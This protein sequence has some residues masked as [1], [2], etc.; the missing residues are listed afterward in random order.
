MGKKR[1]AP[2]A[3][4]D[5]PRGAVD[6]H[7]VL[8]ILGCLASCAVRYE[9][10]L[11]RS[12]NGPSLQPTMSE[13]PSPA[14]T[15]PTS[16]NGAT[17]S[18]APGIS[19][20]L[21][22]PT[23]PQE[24]TRVQVQAQVL[25]AAAGPPPVALARS[26]TAAVVLPAAAVP[27]PLAPATAS[28]VQRKHL[29]GWSPTKLASLSFFLQA[30]QPTQ[31]AQPAAPSPATAP[32]PSLSIFG[33]AGAAGAVGVGP[34][35][36]AAGAGVAGTAAGAAE[37]QRQAQGSGLEGP[38]P[39]LGLRHLLL[40]GPSGARHP[41]HREPPKTPANPAPPPPLNSHAP[42]PLGWLATAPSP[43]SA[44]EGDGLMTSMD[45]PGPQLPGSQPPLGAG[46]QG[47]GGHS[48]AVTPLGK[49]TPY[50]PPPPPQQQ[51]RTGGV[52]DM[53]VVQA[54]QF[55]ST[56]GGGP[57]LAGTPL[58]TPRLWPGPGFRVM[59][60]GAEGQGGQGGQGMGQKRG[61]DS[62]GTA[63]AT[64]PLMTSGIKDLA[65][66]KRQRQRY[67]QQ[68]SSRALASLGPTTP[69]S[70]SRPLLTL[71]PA[72]GGSSSSSHTPGAGQLLAGG[73]KAGRA[74]GRAEH[75]AEGGGPGAGG[76]DTPLAQQAAVLQGV[77]Q[78]DQ[79]IT[80]TARYIMQTLD[81]MAKQVNDDAGNTPFPH[82]RQG[83]AT[84]TTHPTAPHGRLG[85]TP[86]QRSS[87]SQPP[88]LDRL[89]PQ[90]PPE[91][92]R[93]HR[94]SAFTPPPAMA[95]PLHPPG[96]QGGRGTPLGLLLGWAAGV[97]THCPPWF[98]T[99][100]LSLGRHRHHVLI[101][102]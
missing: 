52:K 53:Q 44:M 66:Y 90:E 45:P 41:Q 60:S 75:E 85:A 30:Q 10:P 5:E 69:H 32:A 37:G 91:G 4:L 95:A 16:K 59:G 67:T 31:P 98:V 63:T 84:S 21:A 47:G 99:L 25:P 19:R 61:R 57:S 8:E 46:V 2:G 38:R 27:P 93:A 76:G 43:W 35:T 94:N 82:A 68:P 24:L 64:T 11:K 74:A 3:K 102:A 29:E 18:P 42:L 13:T 72:A 73:G 86:Y 9:L 58:G 55:A 101:M 15:L 56:P 62:P 12:G 97:E 48:A 96:P 81:S 79:G 65:E 77:P 89:H 34:A 50:T 7:L 78:A 1:G 80:D 36:G 70:T 26:V 71:R 20:Q 17:V 87:S 92:S 6:V 49:P 88:P 14:P 23:T 28:L 54:L 51:Q 22:Q 100:D 40:Q 39:Y 83:H 33:A